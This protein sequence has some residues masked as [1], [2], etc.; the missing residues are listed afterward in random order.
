M[1]CLST[2]IV[3]HYDNKFDFPI[4]ADQVTAKEETSLILLYE[5]A[6]KALSEGYCAEASCRSRQL[7]T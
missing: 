6:G 7:V 5:L 3:V 2:T 1:L 4:A